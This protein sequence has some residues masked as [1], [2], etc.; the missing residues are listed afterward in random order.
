MQN[1]YKH[2]ANSSVFH[3]KIFSVVD[4]KWFFKYK[5]MSLNKSVDLFE[6]IFW[7]ESLEWDEL[8]REN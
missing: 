1:S 8:Q 7:V 5:K 4:S 2:L 6:Y 3:E